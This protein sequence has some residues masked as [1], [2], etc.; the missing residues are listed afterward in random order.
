[1][2]VAKS[3]RFEKGRESN[4]KKE[5]ARRLHRKTD[6][7]LVGGATTEETKLA[8]P[9]ETIVCEVETR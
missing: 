4:V 6:C 7:D 9:P 2:A 8:M 1:M 5:Q 3:K